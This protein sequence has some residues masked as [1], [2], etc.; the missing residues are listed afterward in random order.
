AP[1][2]HATLC[3]GLLGSLDTHL[4]YSLGFRIFWLRLAMPR[5]RRARSIEPGE[6]RAAILSAAFRSADFLLTVAFPF[7]VPGNIAGA[8]Q[9]SGRGPWPFRIPWVLDACRDAQNGK[10]VVNDLNLNFVPP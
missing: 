2:R 7:W 3:G 8:A 5:C 1:V 6:Y 10:R 4:L 9:A